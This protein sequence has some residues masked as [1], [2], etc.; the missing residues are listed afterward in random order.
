MNRY[1]STSF[2]YEMAK[3]NKKHKKQLLLIAKKIEHLEKGIQENRIDADSGAFLLIQ[4][5]RRV[6]QL[7]TATT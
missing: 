3:E 6:A 2:I 7:L 5:R 4:A 1:I